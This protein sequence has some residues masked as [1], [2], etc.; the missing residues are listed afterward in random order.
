MKLA[1]FPSPLSLLPI[2][3]L[4]P[5][6]VPPSPSP[7]LLPWGSRMGEGKKFKSVELEVGLEGNRRDSGR[8]FPGSLNPVAPWSSALGWAGLWLRSLFWWLLAHL[9]LQGGR[10]RKGARDRHSWGLCSPPRLVLAPCWLPQV[11][12]EFLMRWSWA[13]VAG[14]LPNALEDSECK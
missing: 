10:G 9:A 1:S 14:P 3:T 5:R 11:F 12:T 7:P 2:P 8:S 13:W 4:S 6:A